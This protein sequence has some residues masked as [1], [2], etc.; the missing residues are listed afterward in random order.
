MKLTPK[1]KTKLG[2]FLYFLDK[3]AIYLWGIN[4]TKEI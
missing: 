3:E 4:R 1:E 2:I